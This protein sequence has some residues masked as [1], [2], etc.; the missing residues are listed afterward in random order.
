[1]AM[2]FQIRHALH[3]VYERPVFLEPTTLRLTPRSDPAQQLLHYERRLHPQPRGCSRVLEADGG[4]AVVLWFGPRQQQLSIAVEMVVRTTRHNA[5]DW[6]V[7]HP[8][9]LQLPAA[10]PPQW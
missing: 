6:I 1:M 3:Y 4:E 5:F 2:L 9:A 8:P 10:Y 7:T